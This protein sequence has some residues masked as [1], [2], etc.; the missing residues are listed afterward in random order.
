MKDAKPERL[1]R[2]LKQEGFTEAGGTKHLKMTK[3]DITLTVPLHYIIKR[4]T[5]D[6]IRK[7]AGIDKKVFY[8]YNLG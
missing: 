4:N 3:G 7:Q 2:A 6:K 8:S 1:V 5:V